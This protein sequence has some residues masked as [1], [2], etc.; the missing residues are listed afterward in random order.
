M[1]VL[2]IGGC[3]YIGSRLREVLERDGH[4]VDSVDQECRG[5]PL[6]Q[7]NRILDYA[8]LGPADLACYDF[9]VLLAAHAS[10]AAAADDPS[11]AFRNNVV[12]F[13]R[14]LE[15]LAG[16]ALIYASS[17]SVYTGLGSDR[18][19]EASPYYA[20]G[21]LYD[22]SK[23]VGDGLAALSR[24]ETYGLRFGTVNG[25]SPNTRDEL[26]L[27]HMVKTALAERSVRV[28]NVH[29][30]RPILGLEDLCRAVVAI[31]R[32][33]G[34]PGVYNLAS[35]NTTVLEAGVAVSRSL[36]VPIWVGHDSP[37]YDFS[38]DTTKFQDT[39]GF[40]FSQTMESIIEDLTSHYSGSR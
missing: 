39:F 17:S 20:M 31:L 40:A 12:A 23:F 15:L 35:F 4:Q 13:H 14:L 11:G 19:S 22:F 8:E 36:D 9:V 32:G 25:P 21:N 16:R 29:V 30:N 1:K 5:N 7:P 38:L 10:V 6:G 2:L 3:G 24:A 18:A 37:T 28:S 26:M 33:G 27:N 34:E